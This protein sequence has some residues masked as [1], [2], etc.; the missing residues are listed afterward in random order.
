M[1]TYRI[2]EAYFGE[3]T[4]ETR[5]NL[6]EMY[7]GFFDDGMHLTGDRPVVCSYMFSRKECTSMDMGKLELPKE[8]ATLDD[9][10]KGDVLTWR[11][12]EGHSSKI[13]VEK[14]LADRLL[15]AYV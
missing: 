4:E 11:H 14:V 12:R 10:V 5:D 8:K 2:I 1:K 13:K 9:L 15:S 3:G 7:I 6:H